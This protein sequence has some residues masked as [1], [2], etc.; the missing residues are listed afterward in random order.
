MFFFLQKYAAYCGLTWVVGRA[1]YAKGYSSGDP[2]KRIPGFF[3]SYTAQVGL[4]ALAAG[5]ALKKLD[6]I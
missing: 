1:L 4:V 5:F 6:I 2:D 3:I